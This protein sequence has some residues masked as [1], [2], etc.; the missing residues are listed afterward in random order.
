MAGKIKNGKDVNKILGAGADFVTIGRS[1]I[2]HH[3][4]PVRVMEDP[5]FTPVVTPVSKNYLHKEGLGEN[6]ITYM[7]RWPGFVEDDS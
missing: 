1:A 7:K 3:D 2:L 6:F 4:F 5:N